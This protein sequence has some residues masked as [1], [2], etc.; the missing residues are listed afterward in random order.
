MKMDSTGSKNSPEII[1]ELLNKAKGK[2]SIN[3]IS[4]MLLVPPE[5]LEQWIAGETVPKLHYRY[6][7]KKR[8]LEIIVPFKS[9][10][11]PT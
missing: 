5:K 8:L 6:I 10:K 9:T 11:N 1:V 3:K 4:E 7:L 2:L